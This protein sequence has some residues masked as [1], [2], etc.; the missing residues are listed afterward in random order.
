MIE[1]RLTVYSPEEAEI[2]NRAMREVAEHRDRDRTTGAATP[3]AV[4]D[5]K[6][7][8]RS[9]K[10]AAS[11]SSSVVGPVVLLGPSYEV[12]AVTLVE[13]LAPEP[14]VKPL[15]APGPDIKHTIVVTK[16]QLREMF[17]AYAATS[18]ERAKSLLNQFGVNRFG[19]LPEEKFSAFAV[20]LE[21]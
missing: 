16:E 10:K 11:E 5:E 13:A 2:A 18:V 6:P 15:D 1:Y 9:R 20:A 4:V 17:S 3:E 19:E 7:A 14:I 8:R 21:Q 12:P